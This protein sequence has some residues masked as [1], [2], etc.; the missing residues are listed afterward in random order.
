MF[1]KK[2]DEKHDFEVYTIFDSKT[3]TYEAPHFEVNAEVLKRNLLNMFNDPSQAKNK[4]LVN[5]EDYSLFRVGTYSKAT[6]LLSSTG[7]EHVAN[8]NDLRA[9]CNWK[10]EWV[11]FQ[12]KVQK[13]PQGIV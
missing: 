4:Y 2:N 6:G 1:A 12:E 11:T 7:L 3:K 5:A 9:L 8:F 10:P 13:G